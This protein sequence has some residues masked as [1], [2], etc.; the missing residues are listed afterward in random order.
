MFGTRL[1]LVKASGTEL[2]DACKL[3]LAKPVRDSMVIIDASDTTTKHAV[4]KLFDQIQ[5]PP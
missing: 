3:L 2:L 4:V 5:P 1:V